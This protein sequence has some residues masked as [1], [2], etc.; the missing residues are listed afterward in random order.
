MN[1]KEFK[2]AK[3]RCSH[4]IKKW[5]FPLGLNWYKIDIDYKM[6]DAPKSYTGAGIAPFNCNVA[7][8]YRTALI[9]IYIEEIPEK[10]DE[11]EHAIVH[12]LCHIFV[13]PMRVCDEHF[14][15]DREEYTVEMLTRAFLWQQQTFEESKKLSLQPALKGSKVSSSKENIN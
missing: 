6:G 9:T 8:Q 14:D 15:M 12:E 7:W 4:Y 3:A 11:L 13:N 2:K 1:D 5:S 10:E